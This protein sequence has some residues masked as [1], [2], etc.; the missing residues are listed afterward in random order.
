M[1]NYYRNKRV[2][3]LKFRKRLLTLFLTAA[4]GTGGYVLV[5][6]LH[7][8]ANAGNRISSSDFSELPEVTLPEYFFPVLGD[9]TSENNANTIPEATPVPTAVPTPI[10]TAIPTAVPTATPVPAY[11]FDDGFNRGDSVIATTDVNLRLNTGTN[12]YKLGTL[13]QGSVVNRILSRD[14]WDLIRYGDTIAYVSSDYTKECDVDYNDEYYRVEDYS[15]IVR[16]TS[17]VYFRLG[18][19]TSEKDICLLD[20]NE[21]L[22]VIGK[23][24]VNG[25]DNNVWY[26]AR[27][28]GQIGFI[29]AEYTKS[30]RSILSGVDPSIQDVQVKKMGYVKTETPIYDS[31]K[32]VLSFAEKYQLAQILQEGESYYLVKID[33]AVGIVA[34][35]DIKEIK[36]SFLVVDISD[37]TVCLY[38]D[39]DI[40]FQ[41]DCTTGKKNSPTHLGVYE[42]YGKSSS[43]NFGPSH[44]N[45]EAR[46]LWM[47]FNGGEGFHDAPWEGASNFGSYDYAMKHGSAGCVR[48]PDDAAHFIYDNVPKSTMVIIK[49]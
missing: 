10:P 48:L 41:A 13:P 44:N 4:I 32:N 17:K 9:N 37:Q 19:S 47:P 42:P 30:L 7:Q 6:T 16:T 46:I 34:K 27:A 21:E 28:H 1:R 24:I 20:K 8:H 35:S 39:T 3:K 2:Q 31:S 36:G 38:C 15:D 22:I 33:T 26:V 25:D 49:Q 14:N 5:D 11:G 45:F 29:K 40:A 43:H 12:S 18:P 23:A